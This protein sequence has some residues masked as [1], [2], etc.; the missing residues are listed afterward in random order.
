MPK[1][2]G[3]NRSYNCG[4]GVFDSFHFALDAF[5]CCRCKFRIL[6]IIMTDWLVLIGSTSLSFIRIY[7]V[8]SV[9]VL[10]RLKPWTCWPINTD[11]GKP[12]SVCC[13]IKSWT[14]QLIYLWCILPVSFYSSLL[15]LKWSWDSHHAHGDILT[16]IGWCCT[17]SSQTLRCRSV[18]FDYFTQFSLLTQCHNPCFC[19]F[20]SLSFFSFLNHGCWTDHRWLPR[21]TRKGAHR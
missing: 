2:I 15:S 20:L 18:Y 14:F 19:F 17:Q 7:S 13:F 21:R 3:W 8:P 1:W 16:P 4:Q 10:F 12:E 6:K 9:R 11:S 5:N